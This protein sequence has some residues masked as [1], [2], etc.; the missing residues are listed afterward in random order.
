MVCKFFTTENYIRTETPTNLN[1]LNGG[2][3]NRLCRAVMTVL[4]MILALV[5]TTSTTSAQAFERW[6]E[7]QDSLWVDRLNTE[8]A[9]T[10]PAS[11][12]SPSYHYEMNYDAYRTQ[13]LFSECKK[14][15]ALLYLLSWNFE[16]LVHV[17]EEL[18]SYNSRTANFLV[19]AGD[20]ISFY[21]EMEWYNPATNEMFTTNYYALD[22]LEMVVYLVNGA[23]GSPLVQLD[24]IGVLP[25]TT[26]GMP[27]IYGARPIMALVSYKVP[28]AFNGDSV[29][30]GIT[31]KAR[32][33]GPHHYTR[34]DGFTIGVSERLKMAE[35]QNYLT[36]YGGIY[37]KRS[38][39]ELKEAS[40]EEGAVLKVS[41]LPGSHRDLRIRFNGPS[42][43]GFTAVAIYDEAGNLVF[44]PYNSRTDRTES[45]TIYR[46]PASG[47]YFVTLAHNGRIVKTQKTIITQ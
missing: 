6:V 5:S 3:M 30:V 13:F 21:R 26:P 40:G 24:S 31:I 20:T 27:T 28:Q 8:G 18:M 42:D 14:N 43:G 17:P 9:D 16:S 32:G 35:Y 45:E 11:W 29:F 7:L 22:T 10:V 37:A 23:D 34:Y 15:G 4:I 1:L 47:A 33:S 19:H 39:D 38:I 25:R 36:A 46:A 2:M 44:Y 41:S 12:F